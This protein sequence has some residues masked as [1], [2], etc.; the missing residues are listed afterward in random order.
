MIHLKDLHYAAG[1]YPIF[2]QASASIPGRTRVGV[3]GANGSGKTTLFRLILGDVVPDSGSISLP[4]GCRVGTVAQDPP[5]SSRSLLQTVLAA[6]REREAL[7]NSAATENDAEALAEIH[8]RLAEIDS[9]SAEAR[10]SSLLRGLGFSQD[11]LTRGCDELSGGWRM[12]V[13]LAAALFAAPDWLLLDEPTNFLD[14]DGAIWLESLL[15]RRRSSIM[16]ISHDVRMLKTA[17][18]AILHVQQGQL[19]YYPYGFEAFLKQ[20]S[21]A[22]ASSAQ[23]A[24][25]IEARRKHIQSFVDRFRYKATKARQ[26]QARIKMLGRLETVPPVRLD[27]AVS[28]TF[29]QPE[30]RSPPVFACERV[31]VGYDRQR[32]LLRNLD[33]YIGSH[34]RIA[35]LGANGVGKSTLARF[36]AGELGSFSGTVRTSPKLKTVLFAQHRLKELRPEATPVEHLAS[37]LPELS[38]L[39]V[40]NRLAGFD[41]V[42]Q[43]ADMRVAELS[44]GQQT[45][46]SL[47]LATLEAP[48]LLVMDEPTNHLDMASRE[49]LGLAINR[50]QGSVILVSH[51]F[52][53][54]ELTCDRLW[55]VRDGTV[56]DFD[57][58]LEAYRTLILS[59]ERPRT[60]PSTK[61]KAPP[62][63]DLTRLRQRI[64]GCENRISK[65]ENLKAMLDARLSDPTFYQTKKQ[66]KIRELQTKHAIVVKELNAAEASWLELVERLETTEQASGRSNRRASR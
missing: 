27:R 20:R 40:R 36:L 53:L 14:L 29:P 7:L 43:Q 61:P 57:G 49:A 54:L 8:M 52:H 31:S 24:K 16:I 59:S 6:D 25:R 51:D 5:S 2:R 47:L 55:L 48:D 34:E 37:A 28:F 9:Y 15:A 4:S 56:T 66:E 22:A 44:G 1:G 45:R 58:D 23:A 42:A 65:L 18:N 21:L 13:A 3:V 50:Y 46:L 17:C 12:R 33:L 63:C 38:D 30:P 11:D 41:L 26:A 39:E 32:P 62:T 64:G 19:T 35:L 10:A 60:K